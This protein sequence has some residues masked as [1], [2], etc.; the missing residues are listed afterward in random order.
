MVHKKRMGN[1]SHKKP[2]KKNKNIPSNPLPVIGVHSSEESLNAENHSHETK[3]KNNNKGKINKVMNKFWGN[4]EWNA[5]NVIAFLVLI[6]GVWALFDSNKIYRMTRTTFEISNRPFLQARAFNIYTDSQFYPHV[7]FVIENLGNYPAKI[8]T[9]NHNVAYSDTLT[10]A[11]FNTMKP[12]LDSTAINVYAVKNTPMDTIRFTAN[13]PLTQ[14][15]FWRIEAKL[16]KFYFFGRIV[17]RDEAAE[18]T[19]EYRFIIQGIQRGNKIAEVR[20]VINDNKKFTS[21]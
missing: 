11:I 15:Q 14:D 3:G 7:D 9:N 5:Q 16:L 20:F 18:E 17:Y 6:V 10:E 12:N 8:L 2:K 13:A 19:R 21:K 4:K 1:S